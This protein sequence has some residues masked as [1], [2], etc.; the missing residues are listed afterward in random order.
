MRGAKGKEE[1]NEA[2]KHEQRGI[3]LGLAPKAILH[4]SMHPCLPEL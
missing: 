2:K 4:V 1:Q 3:I